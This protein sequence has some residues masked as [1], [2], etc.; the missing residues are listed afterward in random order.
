MYFGDIMQE[1]MLEERKGV[2]EPYPLT[3]ASMKWSA[4][5]IGTVTSA[6]SAWPSEPRWTEAERT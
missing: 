6:F 1:E 5:T 3:L 4:L 2:T